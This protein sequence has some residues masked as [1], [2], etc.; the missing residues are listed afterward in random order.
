V[1]EAFPFISA[2]GLEVGNKNEIKTRLQA[3]RAE[4]KGKASPTKLLDKRIWNPR[5]AIVRDIG[6]LF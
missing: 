2:L 3:S 6:P 5:P 4:M 1:G